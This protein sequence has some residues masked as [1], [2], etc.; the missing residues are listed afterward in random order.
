MHGH[1][2]THLSSVGH[3]GKE[4]IRFAQ[5]IFL[6]KMTDEFFQEGYV[7][8]LPSF[9]EWVADI[10]AVL[11]FRVPGP[12]GKT[13]GK[14]FPVGKIQELHMS[15]GPISSITM[16]NDNQ[17]TSGLK[18]RRIRRREINKTFPHKSLVF[19]F[20]SPASFLNVSGTVLSKAIKS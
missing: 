7:V 6:L 3:T 17:R 14:S 4:Y 10:P 18:G 19:K 1:Q 20:N 5:S 2:V 11:A 12:C 9:L 15:L 16:E 8:L 13:Y